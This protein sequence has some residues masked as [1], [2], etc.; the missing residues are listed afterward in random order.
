MRSALFIL[1]V[2]A[3]S[4]LGTAAESRPGRHVAAPPA[5]LDSANAFFT[6]CLGA[7]VFSTYLSFAPDSTRYVPY[8]VEYPQ[9]ADSLY[10]LAFRIADPHNDRVN[11]I[12]FIRVD[13]S[14]KVDRRSVSIP[15]CAS[16]P[17]DCGFPITLKEANS[18]A[19]AAGL[20]EHLNPFETVF[21]WHPAYGRFFWHIRSIA[22]DTQ[23]STH[24]RNAYV[25]AID[26]TINASHGLRMEH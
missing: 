16:D 22:A 7:D 17:I 12:V 14:G 18:I 2:V 15:R 24:W 5:V 4:P 6:E 21:I 13:A 3:A 19:R 10:S 25:D 1:L 8:N 20:H 26:G 11:E 9:L 23:D